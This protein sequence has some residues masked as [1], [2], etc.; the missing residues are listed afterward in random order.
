M[1]AIFI[2]VMT[3]I[4]LVRRL[5]GGGGVQRLGGAAGWAPYPQRYRDPKHFERMY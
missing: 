4:G 5:A 2:A 1:T 3:P